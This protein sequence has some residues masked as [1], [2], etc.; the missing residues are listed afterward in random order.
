MLWEDGAMVATEIRG[1]ILDADRDWLLVEKIRSDS[2]DYQGW[3]DKDRGILVG[4]N[5]LVIRKAIFE[6]GHTPST[7]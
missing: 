4:P 7:D 3:I 2:V 6:R 5:R 1:F